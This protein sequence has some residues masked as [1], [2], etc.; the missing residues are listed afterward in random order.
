MSSA[1]FDPNK[2]VKSNVSKDDVIQIK[3]TFDSIDADHN[4]SISPLEIR[5]FF[6]RLQLEDSKDDIYSILKEM[7][8]D[9]SGGVDF[10]EFLHSL[11]PEFTMRKR[12]EKKSENF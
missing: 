6:Q 11:L 9:Y 8:D 12:K 2:Y 3:K 4:N 5:A 7:D 1:S 10:E